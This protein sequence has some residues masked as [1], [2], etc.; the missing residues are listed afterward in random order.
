MSLGTRVN[1]LR[2]E[3][4]MKQLD[5]ATAL[6]VTPSYVS[7]IEADKVVPSDTLI[8]MLSFIFHVEERW[9]KT[10]EGTRESRVDQIREY[11]SS[12]PDLRQRLTQMEFR[13]QQLEQLRYLFAPTYPRIWDML[14]LLS[15]DSSLDFVARLNLLI[16]EWDT[17]DIKNRARIEVRMEDMIVDF[18]AK[19]SAYQRYI[20]KRKNDGAVVP[21]EEIAATEATAAPTRVTLPVI[22]RAAAGAPKSMIN[23]EGEE[24]RTNGDVAHNI[25][26]GD[27]IVIAD[28]DSMIDCGIHDGDYCVIHQ[29]PEVDNGQ[30]ALVAVDDGSTIKR[31]YTDDSGFR[32]VPCNTAY[33]EQHYPPD[34]PIRVLG[35]F[36]K[37]I[38][39]EA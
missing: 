27:F 14:K 19:I 9:I 11:V 3:K 16:K 29:T 10:G 8:S 22:G 17:S 35:K 24:L 15:D 23:L 25:R 13:E 33:Q 34:A 7:R 31:F 36:V 5:L 37:V 30:I 18:P 12:E 38:L 39:P 4:N 28:G 6:K 20:S 21:F 1:K 32:L 26:P 2:A